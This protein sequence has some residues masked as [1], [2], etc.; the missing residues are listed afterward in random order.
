MPP[1]LY[2]QL[3]RRFGPADQPNRRDVL[4]AAERRRLRPCRG[5]LEAQAGFSTTT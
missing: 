1:T 4:K 3:S 5:L 2:A